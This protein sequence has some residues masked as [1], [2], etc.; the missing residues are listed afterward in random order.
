VAR[1]CKKPATRHRSSEPEAEEYS[2]AVDAATDGEQRETNDLHQGATA[3]NTRD[4]GDATG[5]QRDAHGTTDGVN[6]RQRPG[7]IIAVDNSERARDHQH[8]REYNGERTIYPPIE[9]A[10]LLQS[11]ECLLREEGPRGLRWPAPVA[12][13]P[14]RYG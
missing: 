11:S 1:A 7:Y 13:A 3:G 9:A 5:E 2:Q 10:G 6:G 12:C 14:T 4:G 8:G